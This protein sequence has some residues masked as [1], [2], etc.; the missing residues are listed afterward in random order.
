M[1]S[2]VVRAVLLG[3]AVGL[4]GGPCGD[5]SAQTVRSGV[6]PT[7]LRWGPQRPD[8]LRFNRVEALSIGARA[9][10]RPSSALGPLSVTATGRLGVADLEPNGRLD[11]TRETLRHRLTVSAYNELTALDETARHLGPANSA[12]AA[13]FGR[14]D[15]DYFYRSGAGVEW[16][17][18]T[19]ARR[20]F[21]VGVHAEYHRAA[22]V[23]HSVSLPRAFDD[24]WIFRPNVVAVDGWEY[25]VSAL[26]SPWWGTDPLLPRGGV[27]AEVRAGTG[28]ADFVRASVGGILFLPLVP[29]LRVS[30]EARGGTTWGS[31]TPQRL[32]YVGGAETVRGYAPRTMAGT[33]F[34]LARAEIQRTMVFG[35]LVV[36]SDLGWAGDRRDVTLA[37]GLASVGAGLALVDGLVRVDVAR[38]LREP[39]GTRADFYLDALR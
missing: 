37:T 5:V 30:L 35:G 1:R 31:P 6:L 16:T 14:D 26:V 29:N 22:V 19:A 10:L 38:R 18:P 2:G 34:A 32:W 11:V 28:T 36:F 12:M 13:V 4:V 33:T 9:Q 8:L 15:G 25:G 20:A 3:L 24:T 17:P 23:E 27:S 21:R 7:T 39:R